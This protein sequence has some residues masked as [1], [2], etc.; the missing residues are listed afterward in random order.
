VGGGKS[1]QLTYGQYLQKLLA[2]MEMGGPLPESAFTKTPYVTDWLDTDESQR[3]FQ[4]QRHSFDDI[5][6]DIAALLTGVKRS[7]ARLSQPVVREY[8]L[9]LSPYYRRRGHG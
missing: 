9:G 3:T 8:M 7:L 1:C 6:R 2:A 5:V 4:Y